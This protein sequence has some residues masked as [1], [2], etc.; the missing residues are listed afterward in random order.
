LI[1]MHSIKVYIR[2]PL[3]I[4]SNIGSTAANTRIIL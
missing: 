2:T 3:R 1:E 4:I